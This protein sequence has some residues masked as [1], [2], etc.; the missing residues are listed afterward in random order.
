MK[1]NKFSNTDNIL[2]LLDDKPN[3]G[4]EENG[5][6]TQSQSNKFENNIFER[7]SLRTSSKSKMS[8]FMKKVSSSTYLNLILMLFQFFLAF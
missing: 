2:D 1:I 5:Q 3:D 8:T 6:E 7:N 4:E